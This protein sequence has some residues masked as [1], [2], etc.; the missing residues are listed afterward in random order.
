MR[1]GRRQGSVGKNV[2]KT[3]GELGLKDHPKAR[4]QPNGE[5]TEL[6][7]EAD[8]PAL[9]AYIETEGLPRYLDDQKFHRL[10][11]QASRKPTWP[12]NNQGQSEIILDGVRVTISRI[13]PTIRYYSHTTAP[14]EVSGVAIDGWATIR[15]YQF[16]SLTKRQLATILTSP[17]P[18]IRPDASGSHAGGTDQSG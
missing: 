15:D 11:S 10:L 1:A 12:K 13:G 9:K 16:A 7:Q 14:A 6:L 17:I 2:F 8:W 18:K 4:F 5:W 3:L